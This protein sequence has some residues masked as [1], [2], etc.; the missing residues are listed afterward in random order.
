MTQP[1]PANSNQASV[2]PFPKTTIIELV[3]RIQTL[4][5]DQE[6]SRRA[7]QALQESEERFRLISETIQFGVFETD[8]RGSCLYTNTRYHEIFEISLAESLNTQWF[9]FVLEQDRQWVMQKWNRTIEQ[10]APLSID[11]RIKSKGGVERWI[12]VQSSPVFSDDG[13]RYT[14]RCKPADNFT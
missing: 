1:R 8:E 5:T 7:Q 14:G 2:R 11:C 4:E 6:K 3:K 13:A 9:D 10:M 12:H